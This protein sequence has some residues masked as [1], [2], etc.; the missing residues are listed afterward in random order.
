MTKRYKNINIE[1]IPN[2]NFEGYYWFSNKPKPEIIRNEKIDKNKFT[3]LPFVVE[4]NF[5]SKET[6]T[7]V[8][9]KNIDGEYH[10]AIIDLTDCDTV[11]Q[12]YIGHDIGYDFQVVEA[13]EEKEDKFLEGM[14]TKVPAWTAFKGF[15]KPKNQKND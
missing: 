8:Q 1:G 7:S 15:V 10:I 5:Y 14:K 9:V 11:P 12:V 4:A 2:E 3:Q 6:E 13:W